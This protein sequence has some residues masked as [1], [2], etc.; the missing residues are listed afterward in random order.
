L[1]LLLIGVVGFLG[2]SLIGKVLEN[3]LHLSKIID[4]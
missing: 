1:L 4:E 3:R 2:T